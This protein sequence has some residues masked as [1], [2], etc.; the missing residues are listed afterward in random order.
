M[1]NTKLDRKH[2]PFIEKKTWIF[3]LD[4]VI[5]KGNEGVPGAPDVIGFLK[6]RSYNVRYLTNNSTRTPEQYVEILKSFG[7]ESK[8]DEIHTSAT[9]TAARLLEFERNKGTGADTRNVFVIGEL[10]LV[11]T[12]SKAGF[13]VITIDDIKQRPGVTREISYVVVGLDRKLTYEKLHVGV[14]CIMNGAR[15]I[16]TNADATLPIENGIAPGTGA[17]I[18]A[19]AFCT[20]RRPECGS[21][22]GKPNEMVFDSILKS[23]GSTVSSTIMVGDRLETDILAAKNAG[24]SSILVLTGISTREDI[25]LLNIRP[26]HVI[27]SIQDIMNWFL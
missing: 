23:C 9:I 6:S 24:M 3:D 2:D 25:S 26:D 7:I 13:N 27:E 5:Y 8:P 22:F 14:E 1:T 4:G 18:E 11:E 12:I 15:F 16:A 19:L 10:G 21:P 17:I 20:G